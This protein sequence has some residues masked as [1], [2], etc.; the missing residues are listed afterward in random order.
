VWTEEP[1]L[2]PGEEDQAQLCSSRPHPFWEAATGQASKAKAE[3]ARPVEE[4]SVGGS[5]VQA[6]RGV[7][8]FERG[9]WDVAGVGLS[10]QGWSGRADDLD[11][12]LWDG[13][14]SAGIQGPPFPLVPQ[15]T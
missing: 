1:W 8:G 15:H 9:Q 4:E 3:E 10:A 13:A 7:H 6:A 11:N 5:H 14:L 2:F 12:G